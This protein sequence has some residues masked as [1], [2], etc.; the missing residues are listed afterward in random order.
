MKYRLLKPHNLFVIII[1][2]LICNSSFSQV[3]E[4]D[5][6]VCESSTTISAITP[7]GVW[8]N[9]GPAIIV[10]PSLLVTPVNNLAVGANIFTYTVS[11]TGSTNLT[12]TNNKVVATVSTTRTDN[13]LTSTNLTGSAIPV[14]G[15]GEWSLVYPKP[16]VIIA[17]SSINITNASGLPFGNTI[18]RWTVSANGCNDS[19]ELSIDNNLPSN[20]LGSDQSGCTSTFYIGAKTP[21]VGGNGKWTQISGPTVNFDNT[22]IP[23][24][25]ITTPIGTS[26]VRWTINYS[27][28]S[29]SKDF[30]ISNHLPSPNAGIDQTVCK[31]T[32]S[33]S[34]TAPLVSEQGLWSVIDDQGETFSNKSVENPLVTKLKQG[35]TSFQ[36]TLSNAFCSTTDFVQVVNNRPSLNAGPDNTICENTYVLSADNPTPLIGTWSCMDASVIFSNSHSNQAQISNL[37]NNTY[38]L[39]WTVANGTCTAWDNVVIHTDFVPISAGSNKSD[40]SDTFVLSATAGTGYWTRTFGDG[41]IDNSLSY[42]TTARNI[43]AT[44]RFK[45]TLLSGTCTFSNEIEYVNQLPRNSIAEVDKSVCSDQTMLTANPAIGTNEFGAW[46]NETVSGSALIISPSIFQTIVENLNQG[47]NTFKWTIYNQFCSTSDLVDITNN[48]IST[49]A[50][51]DQ[52]ICGSSTSL[53]ATN[54][55]G[56]GYWTSSTAGVV[57]SNS[58]S[59][60]STLSN[61]PFGT[62]TITWSRND[63][64]CTAS[65]EVVITNQLPSTIFAGIDQSVCDNVAY[66]SADNPING[67]GSW[68]RISGTGSIVNSSLY[69]TDVTGLS[70]G[71]NVFRWT[72][73]YQA[74]SGFDDVLISNNKV[75]VSAGSDQVICNQTTANL[76]GTEPLLG[77]TGIWSI[78]GGSGNFT[79][80]SLFNT[81]VTSTAKGTN[82]YKW[83]LSDASCSNSDQ[84]IITNNSPDL[85]KVADDKIICIDNTPINAIAVTN[86]VGSWSVFSGGGIIQN[87]NLNNTFVNNITY[88]GL[89]TYRWTVNKNGCTLFADLLV[90]NNSVDAVIPN[91][92]YNICSSL[93]S[94]TLTASAPNDGATGL[95]TKISAGNGTIVSPSNFSTVI[96]NL[97]N[98]EMRFRWTVANAYC[99]ALDET[100]VIN[101]Y[102]TAS[103][104]PVGSANLCVN[105]ANA[106]GTVPPASAISL[107]TA[108]KPGIT[109]SNASTATTTVQNLP[110]G[111]STIYWTINNNKCAAQASFELF[112]YSITTNAG[113]DAVG[114]LPTADLSAQALQMGQSGYWTANYAAITFSNS[115]NPIS[116]ASN[117]PAGTCTITWTLNS[118]GCTVSDNLSVT[119]YSFNVSAGNDKTICVTDYSLTGSD[120][121]TNGVG[122]W[123]VIVGNAV[124]ANPANFN[125]NASNLSNGNNTFRWTVQRNGCTAID[126]VNIIN[127]FYLALASAPSNVCIGEVLATATALPVGSGTTAT[128]STLLGGGIFDDASA[129]ITM[130]RNLAQGLNRFRWT[131]SKGNCLSYKNV[132][133]QNDIINISAGIDQIICVDNTSLF[134]MPLSATGTGMWTCNMPGVVIASPV[135]AFTDVNYLIKGDNQFTW[136][137]SDKGCTGVAQVTVTNSDFTAFAGNDQMVKV[138]SVNMDAQYPS[139]G[140]TGQWTILNGNGTFN[141]YVS[142][143]ATLSNLGYGVNTYRWTVDWNGCSAYDEV[144]VTYNVAE[145][146]AGEDQ[147]S[148]NNYATLG[149]NPPIMGSGTWSVVSGTGQ[150]QNP[151]NYTTLVN[152]VSP[153][154]NVYRWLVDAFGSIAS[155]DVTITNN[156]FVINAGIDQASCDTEVFMTAEAAGPGGTG[157]WYVFQG[158]GTFDSNIDNNSRVSALLV[159]DNRYIWEVVRNGCTHRD[160]VYVNHY[161]PT[162]IADAGADLF[163]CNKNNYILTANFPV[164]GNGLWSTNDAG[165]TFAN[166][167]LSN[168]TVSNLLNGPNTLWW[169]ITNAQCE[170]ADDIV[171]YARKSVSIITEPISKEWKQGENLAISIVTDGDVQFYQWQKDGVNLVNDGRIS[172]VNQADLNISNLYMSDEGVY[173]CIV[174]GYCNS[175]NSET[176]I[177]SVISG[178]EELN[179]KGIKIYPNPSK[180]IVYLEFENALMMK[181]LNISSMNG[182]KVFFKQTLNITETIDMTNYADGIYFISIQSGD[183]LIRSKLILQK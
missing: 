69:Q 33:L 144:A 31:D 138:Q 94:I 73:S 120:P 179:E 20:T 112:N 18:F 91:D 40:C 117:I 29:S 17:N 153:G 77:Q 176:A 130:A 157:M 146:Y 101:D 178:F 62:N 145:S 51:L 98:G 160:T 45:W 105:Y 96:S 87:S 30:N 16:G 174:T 71:P 162:T 58:T 147:V 8:S 4:P 49:N 27:V 128:W 41:A 152:N 183:E 83:T 35:T 52:T 5:R 104:I 25:E 21:P 181:N 111:T 168:T 7:G 24:V 165:I 118:N 6:A 37:L 167:S 173:K 81:E 84:V 171:V 86:G 97:A 9:V 85:A 47:V 107:W 13:C 66:L 67:T 170:S 23:G 177:V 126:E 131:V 54:A 119:N 92:Q 159:G 150:F 72:V 59:P 182:D 89:N 137:V 95:W 55:G 136:T 121:L 64:G 180:G 154:V 161:Q 134:A 43:T 142:P 148:C 140:A 82:T 155:D 99:S 110:L 129:T 61:I 56:T 74:C 57:F 139:S 166:R 10:S 88:R 93:H 135:S 109:F 28:C 108:N 125:T 175:L 48:S 12:I 11:G 44:S 156:T 34:A 53:N 141:D 26:V 151:Q 106:I 116:T 164:F 46:T 15:I 32:V 65:D 123:T 70:I 79:N 50:G 39:T 19:K 122:N 143:T 76:A 169:T 42:S 114:C 1:L 36:W 38:T 113:I 2:V 63:L 149:A 102:Y 158:S 172:G 100:S 133:V 80:A 60:T 3:V 75:S 115:L 90:T 124:V 78:V 132:D 103:A 68:S 14:G 163:I 22:A 127:D